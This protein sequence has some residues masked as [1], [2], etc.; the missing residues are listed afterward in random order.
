MYA[1]T[2]RSNS[3]SLF[4]WPN[5]DRH[6]FL[7]QS[8]SPS[9]ITLAWLGQKKISR[10]GALRRV[11]FFIPLLRLSSLQCSYAKKEK[12][13]DGCRSICGTERTPVSNLSFT[14]PLVLNGHYL[15]APSCRFDES[16]AYINLMTSLSNHTDN[17]DGESKILRNFGNKVHW[18]T[19]Q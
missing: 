9:Q 13:A 11:M 1:H 14:V 7:P 3:F 19:V 18:H 17:E 12:N 5:S 8:S 4:Y 10:H 6:H 2:L 16:H 15:F